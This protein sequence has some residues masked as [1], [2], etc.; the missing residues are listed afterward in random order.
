MDKSVT[1]TIKINK[2]LCDRKCLYFNPS[3]SYDEL[4][5]ELFLIE[6]DSDDNKTVKRCDDCLNAEKEYERKKI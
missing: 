2:K 1:V 3:A 4:F 6:L 5:C